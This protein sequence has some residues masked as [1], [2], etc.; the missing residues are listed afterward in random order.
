MFYFNN[1]KQGR[2]PF[3]F[4]LFLALFLLLAM[5]PHAFA[6]EDTSPFTEKQK[7]EVNEL[8]R[9]YILDNPKVIL[10][11]VQNM[12][13]QNEADKERRAQAAIK[14]RSRDIFNDP[15]SVVG[16]NPNG[17]V[18]LVEFFDYQCGYCKRVYP[19]VRQL[20][21]EDQ[22]IKFVYKEYPILGPASSYAAKA[23]IASIEQGKYQ[24][25]HDA[26][27][28]VKGGLSE[29]LVLKI[30]SAVG[31]DRDK[32]AKAISEQN[33]SSNEIVQS[34]YKLAADLAISGTPAFVIGN[35]IIRG[36]VGLDVLKQLVAEARAS[37]KG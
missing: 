9:K 7:S 33:D 11:S 27:M 16:G 10:E 14:E 15:H 25:F 36:A 3:V 21:K 22:N 29:E 12:E 17:D 32:L 2:T 35:E 37:K 8:I 34:N 13:R 31:L 5:L 4:V 6:A 26:L 18:T 20:L 19:I 30:A 1:V 24:E 28:E 23:S